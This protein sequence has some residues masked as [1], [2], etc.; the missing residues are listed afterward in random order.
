[1]VPNSATLSESNDQHAVRRDTRGHG[2]RS[3]RLHGYDYTQPGAYFVTVCTHDRACLFD[4]PVVRAVVDASWRAIPRHF[5]QVTL[6]AYVIMPNHLH[7]IL[8]MNEASC[9]DD[10]CVGGHGGGPGGGGRGK[11]FACGPVVPESFADGASR[12]DDDGDW[13]NALPLHES[14]I[15]HGAAPGSLGAII[16][17]FK[18]VTSRRINRIRKTPGLTIWQRNYYEHIIRNER[19]LAAIRE[20]IANNP[21]SWADDPE[22][23]SHAPVDCQAHYA[24]LGDVRER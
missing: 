16:G 11:A 9:A 13:A 23:P 8:I 15:R 6:D 10:T 19:A 24:C 17:N 18:A 7:G 2:R 22:N 3:I 21:A 1:V 5:P 14:T 20:Y 4:H 12:L